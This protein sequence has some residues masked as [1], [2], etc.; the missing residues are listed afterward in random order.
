MAP[1]SFPSLLTTREAAEKLGLAEN[2]LA[3]WRLTRRHEIPYFKCGDRVLYD[4]A[5]VAR[6]LESRKVGG[7]ETPEL[8]PA[9]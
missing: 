4:A 6:F 1:V 5:D 9:A 7:S 8:T 2:T 3:N